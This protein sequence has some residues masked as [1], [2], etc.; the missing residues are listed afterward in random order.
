MGDTFGKRLRAIRKQYKLSQTE[1]ADAIN[2]RWSGKVRMSQSTYSVLEQRADP[3]S[4]ELVEILSLYFG[5]SRLYFT[6]SECDHSEAARAY[7]ESLRHRD[8]SQKTKAPWYP[9]GLGI[10]NNRLRDFHYDSDLEFFD[11]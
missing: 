11:T 1:V 8:F 3:P 5:V 9:D 10:R 2:E 4:A 7:L 6:V